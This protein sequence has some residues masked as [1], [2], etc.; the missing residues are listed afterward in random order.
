MSIARTRIRPPLWQPGRHVERPS[1]TRALEQALEPTAPVRLLLACAP[2]GFGKTLALAA[3]CQRASA[4]GWASAWLALDPEDALPQLLEG[5][6]AAL[7]PFDLPWRVDPE[8]LARAGA[9]PGSVPRLANAFVNALEAAEQTHGLIVIDDL[10]RASDPALHEYLVRLLE[11]L[12]TGWRLAVGSRVEPPW[13][14]ARLRAEQGLVDVREEGLRFAPAEAAQLPGAAAV[15]AATLQTLLERTQGWAAGLRLGLDALQHAGA[16][17][18]QRLDAGLFEYLASEVLD[19]LD[20]ELREFLLATAPLPELTAARAAALSGHAGAARLLDQIL[21]RGLFATQLPGSEAGLRLHDLFRDTL[22]HRLRREQPERLPSLLRRAAAGEPELARRIEYG[23]QA[24]TLDGD[25]AGV[26]ADLL[27][28]TPALLTAG[29]TGG[30]RRLLGRFP[31]ARLQG[32]A[33]LLRAQ[34]LLAWA[35][36]DWRAMP[37]Q[38]GAAA[39][40]LRAA[41]EH[42]AAHAVQAYQAIGLAGAGELAAAQVLVDGLQA[43]ALEPASRCRLAVARLWLAMNRGSLQ[44]VVAV[45]NEQLDLLQL[46]ED[47]ALWY[48]CVPLPACVGLAGARAPIQ[49]YIQGVLLRVPDAPTGVRGIALVLQAF[50]QMWAAES[51]VDWEAA[52]RSLA[53]AAEDCHWL[54]RPA[55]LD[56]QLR[57]SQIALHALRGRSTAFEAAARELLADSAGLNAR[58]RLQPAR[59]LVA[60]H[61]GRLARLAGVPALLAEAQALLHEPGP[62]QWLDEAQLAVLQAQAAAQA[63]QPQAALQAWLQVVQT[64][65]RLSVLGL[66]T[67]A[68][69]QAAD[70]LTQSG[71]HEAARE[72][73]ARALDGCVQEPGK[74]ALLGRAAL[75]RLAASPA[76]AALP[77]ARERLLAALPAP[78]VPTAPAT[79]RAPAA[80]LSEREREVLGLLAQGHSNK[81]IAREL[82]L[83]PYTVKRHVANLLDKLD[84][85]SRGQAAAWHRDHG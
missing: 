55:N 78:A 59:T 32:S 77:G 22:L 70:L 17:S 80:G 28:A 24:A 81:L 19:G 33:A 25:W 58:Q 30:L 57:M 47:L 64:A 9:E 73:L 66:E 16:Q 40:L 83:S 39:A 3:L 46:S 48:E 74:L 60:F 61:V 21:Q 75:Q 20:P 65:E 12:P 53:L 50:Q 13:P 76:A 5:L 27:T 56:F 63:G 37:R 45:L 52:E 23:V 85:R 2:A 6:V 41:G 7:D 49:R 14:L 18:P 43:Q 1:L 68:P 8:A 72:L 79:A 26:E 51:E 54:D 10:H 29:D 44:E 67:E 62:G 34:G 4:A 42:Q 15:P 31:A 69:L 35:E 82:G 71:A 11:R 38:M 36:W 84:L